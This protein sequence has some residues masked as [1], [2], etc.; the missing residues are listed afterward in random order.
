MPWGDRERVSLNVYE[1]I[2]SR[3]RFDYGKRKGKKIFL[4]INTYSL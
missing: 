4:F 3:H 2:T 1:H